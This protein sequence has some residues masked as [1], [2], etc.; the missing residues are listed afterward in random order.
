M[1]ISLLGPLEVRTDDGAPVEV[2][3]AR[4]R[5]LLSALALEPG[6]EVPAARLIDAVWGEHP[7][8]TANA[9]QALVSRLRKAGVTL[10]STSAGYRLSA[11]VDVTRFEELAAKARHGD[12]V[13]TVTLLRAALDLWRG[14]VQADGAYFQAPLARLTELRLGAAEDHAEAALRLGGGGELTAELRILL[15]EHPLRERLTAALMRALCAAGRPA[16]ALTAYERL[17]KTL[18]EEL[19]TDP[20]AQ[21]SALHTTILRDSRVDSHDEPRSN[22]RAGLTSFVGR[23]DDVAQVAKLV[24]EYRLTTLTGPG[25]AGKTRLATETARILRDRAPGDV[26]LVELAPITGG[27]DVTQT[28]LTTLGLREQGQL[29]L[30]TSGSPIDRAV[31]ALRGRE[32][33]LVLDNCEHVID[34]AA[35]LAERLLGECPRLR[36]VATSREPLA[37]TGEALWPVEP[38]AVPAQDASVAEAM[39]CA[40]VRLLMDRAAAVR[41]GFEVDASTVDAVTRICR[42]LDGMPLAVELAAARLRSLTIAQLAARLDDRFRLLTAGSRTAL[43]RHRTLRAVVD[44]SWELLSDAERTLLRR[45]VVFSGGAT[46]EAAA[47]V[48]GTEDAPDLLT[49]L[50]DKSLVVVSDTPEPRY[51]MLETIKAYALERLTEAGERELL[52]RAHA[53]W[54]A[55]LAEAA[56]P[57]L[58]RAEQL[59]WLPRLTADHGN[60]TSAVRSAIT[61]GDAATAIRLV[62]ASGWYWLLGG[63]RTEGMDLIVAALSVAG[64]VDNEDRASANA[65]CVLFSTAGLADDRSAESWIHTAL[66]LTEGGPRA[67][68]ALRFMVPLE[69]LLSGTP[70]G[71]PPRLDTL[72][73]LLTDED[74]WLRTHAHLTRARLQF[75]TG[76]G[77]A[78]TETDL[79]ESVRLFRLTG[80]RWGHSLALSSLA[81]IIARNGEL[82]RAVDHYAEAIDVLTEIGTVDDVLHIWGRQAHLLWLKGDPGSAEAA[83]S[84]AD[85]HAAVVISPDA[86]AGLAQAKGDLARWRGDSDAAA[87]FFDQAEGLVQ[88]L[89][90]HPLFRALMA[91]SRAFV[92]ADN[93]NLPA[94]ATQRRTAFDLTTATGDAMYLS[95]VVVGIADHA[96]RTGRA[97]DAARLLKT[98]H[99]LSGGLDY[100]SP[101][102]VRLGQLITVDDDGTPMSMEELRAMVLSV[103]E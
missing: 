29:G 35:E 87:R 73:T 37:V 47:A 64:E 50:V 101:D 23:D 22:L 5:A 34:A 32:A 89:P 92:A 43:P 88:H 63:H 9:L 71:A 102:A 99:E 103:L 69:Q 11:S 26:W 53:T 55:Q 72:D 76:H 95:Q 78:S 39:T 33:L 52:R 1:R 28:V 58:R 25:G 24:A 3:G 79:E 48:C 31:G 90:L 42:A 20:S 13:E 94:A 67:H 65:L 85:R 17:R 14:P 82:H 21:L 45:L 46:S 68:P 8:A 100:S 18:A 77:R 60:L 86:L 98:A 59:E 36:I 83:L 4:L 51:T 96:L 74:P 19:G 80:E 6:R 54:F 2:A 93:G 97:K 56:D 41:P 61:A 66:A 75:N 15:S 81:E 44:W 16:D 40:S 30:T 10:E 91:Q 57:H 12:D 38:L 70:T 49:T 84:A 7:P 27:A 62:V